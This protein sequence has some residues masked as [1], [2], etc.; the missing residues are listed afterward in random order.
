MNA[1][2]KCVDLLISL[3]SSRTPLH[4]AANDGAEDCVKELLALGAKTLVRDN[5]HLKPVD[6]A[7]RKR[8]FNIVGLILETEADRR[9]RKAKKLSK[10]SDEAK[11]IFAYYDA[12][13]CCVC[14]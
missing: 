14:E 6:L 2:G 5:E 12:V 9:M 7:Q 1:D 8:L 10:L 11:K 4:Y 3:T 13:C